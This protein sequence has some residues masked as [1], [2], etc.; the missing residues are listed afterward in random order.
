MDANFVPSYSAAV[1]A[2]IPRIDSYMFPCTGTQLSNDSACKDP[3]TQLSEYLANID[4]NNLTIDTLWFDIEP[5]NTSN[6]DACNAWNLGSDG[7]LAL[8]QQWITLLRSSGRKWGIY[9][10]G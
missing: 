1:S 5:T 2:G 3:A 7:N 6:G 8:A 9:A 10:N 4:N